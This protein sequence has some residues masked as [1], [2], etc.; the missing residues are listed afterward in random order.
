[1]T[2]F[3]PSTLS[4]APVTSGTSSTPSAQIK[5]KL[6]EVPPAANK[7]QQKYN[8]MRPQLPAV[9]QLKRTESSENTTAL[10]KPV[11]TQQF[12]AP[13][14]TPQLERA[15]SAEETSAK[16]NMTA[17]RPQAPPPPPPPPS[18]RPIKPVV[19][20]E[21]KPPP[22]PP[23]YTSVEQPVLPPSVSSTYGARLPVY[24]S[25]SPTVSSPGSSSVNFT[26]SSGVS[27][28][29]NTSIS[30]SDT[31]SSVTLNGSQNRPSTIP[32]PVKTGKTFE[33]RFQFLPI[34]QLPPPEVFKKATA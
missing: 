34:D 10:T 19:E 9:P 22:P 8:T 29:H 18:A 24:H 13:S 14:M 2:I 28:T 25:P 11:K 7:P 33:E 1:M 17:R 6:P 31:Q 30:S 15:D 23:R 16:T 32:A 26:T 5:Q 3:S 27:S 20:D 12:A 21:P 4:S